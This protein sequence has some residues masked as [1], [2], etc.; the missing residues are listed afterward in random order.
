MGRRSAPLSALPS[1]T[2]EL[3]LSSAMAPTLVSQHLPSPMHDAEDGSAGLRRFGFS[4]LPGRRTPPMRRCSIRSGMRG[5]F[6]AIDDREPVDAQLND[7]LELRRLVRV[8]DVI[9]DMPPAVGS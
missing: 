4:G 9:A 8:D 5:S 6:A 7:E 2:I 3:Q 1:L